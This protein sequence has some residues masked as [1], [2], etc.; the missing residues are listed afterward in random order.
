M[1]TLR[2]RKRHAVR[3]G[4]S[5]VAQELFVSKG[6]EATTIDEIAAAAGMSR[7][8]FF[9]YFASKEDVLTGRFELVADDMVVALEER[10]ASESAWDSLR[11]AFDP[12][13]NYYRDPHRRERDAVTWLLIETN[14]DLFASY[15]VKLDDM[16]ERLVGVLVERAVK[17]NGH[18][19]IDN[20]LIR[21]LVG[22]AIECL[23]ASFHAVGPEYDVEVVAARLD[24][25]MRKMRPGVAGE[26]SF[27]EAF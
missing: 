1:M 17:N 16:K 15:L 8:T 14:Q 23:L 25:L 7:R 20:H 6:Y 18:E 3:A 13:I 19:P 11:H 4:I 12:L 24:D 27:T 21:A 2:D 5:E 10:R 9:R 22:A 26:V